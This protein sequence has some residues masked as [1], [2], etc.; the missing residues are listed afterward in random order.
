MSGG[1][2]PVYKKYTAASKGIWEKLRQLLVI[3]PNRST[4]NPVVPMFRVPAPGSRPEAASYEDPA[5][6][7]ASDIADN[8]YYNRDHRRHY[9]RTAFY[10]QSK[11]AGL[12]E[13]GNKTQPRIADGE[14]GHKALAQVNN[15]EL[16]LTQILA[17]TPQDII[18]G[19][20]LDKNGLPPLPPSLVS[21]SY[22]IVPPEESGMY[23]DS[24][25]PVRSFV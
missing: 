7:P 20:V 4:G 14:E 21:K 6:L 18:K 19:S 16:S 1:P 12:L 25:Y 3:V 13:Y 5:T 9:P 10:D 23:D 17:S 11:I 8:R 22:K 2:V 15:G 24:Q